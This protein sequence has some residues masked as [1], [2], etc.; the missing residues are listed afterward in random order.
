MKL[1]L[2]CFSSSLLSVSCACRVFDLIL[3]KDIH[4]VWALKSSVLQ[5]QVNTTQGL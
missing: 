1:I 5:D 3:P 2:G 4:Y